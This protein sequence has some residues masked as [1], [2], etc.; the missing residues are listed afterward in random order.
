MWTTGYLSAFIMFVHD[1][2][3]IHCITVVTLSCRLLLMEKYIQRLLV[4]A[5]VV[6][7]AAA[8]LWKAGADADHDS[9]QPQGGATLWI[10]H[11]W[12]W[13]YWQE[14]DPLYCFNADQRLLLSCLDWGFVHKYS[15]WIFFKTYFLKNSGYS[16]YLRELRLQCCCII[17]ETRVYMR[18]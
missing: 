16:K 4:H 9:S 8:L 10:C 15:T 5:V 3:L 7:D 14:A 6:W 13:I 1:E 12:T 17:R 11:W 2:T 18:W